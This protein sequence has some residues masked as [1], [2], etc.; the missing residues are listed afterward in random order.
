MN[1]LTLDRPVASA[2]PLNQGQQDAA[3]AFFQFLFST[4]R[5]L[6]I[7]GPGGVGKTYLMG[8]L[9]DTIMPRYFDTCKLMNIP[10]E[11]DEVV[12][13]AMTNKAA[14]QL[15]QA[16][17]RPCSTIHSFLNLKVQ[18]DYATGKSTITRTRS[19]KVH[20]K[21]IIFI[22]EC[23]MEDRQLYGYLLE[24]TKNCKI[25]HVG[26]HCQLAPV[27][28]TISPVYKQGIMF[29]QLTEPM[30][31]S[32]QPELMKLCQQLRHTVETSEFKPIRIVPGVIDL[33]DDNQIQDAIAEHFSAQTHTSR[34]LA[35]TN[36]RVIQ[37]NDHIRELRNLPSEF[38][39]GEFL[40][41]NSA[42]HLPGAMLSVEAEVELKDISP[43]TEM[44]WIEPDVGL[45]IR[46]AT[47]QTSLGYQHP[48]VPI[49][50]DRDH[51]AA[52]VKHY[53]R[54]KNWPKYFELKNFVPDLRQ[55]D[56][57]T[58]YKAQGS[59]YDTVF[60]D[61]SNIST[62]NNPNQVARML[63]VAVSR[64]RN[65]IILYGNLADKYGGLVQ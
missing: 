65:R 34:I 52:L 18:D 3:D 61:L 8:H 42:I 21:K 22:D 54:M 50:V 63:Y 37:F 12:M 7:S 45:E 33:M 28:E 29:H 11:F 53:Q 59:T 2:Q 5:Q 32:G 40:V 16:T 30:R 25:V 58:V 48:N 46:K 20:E 35:Y 1:Q 10:P 47:L 38:T 9:I 14:E 15:S 56:A 43:H 6:G 13:T 64:P 27:M 62:C 24:G 39:E 4:D 44:H 17:G 41:N 23:S 31:N 55:A 19:W 51:F 57:S 60:I 49:P 26:D 36:A